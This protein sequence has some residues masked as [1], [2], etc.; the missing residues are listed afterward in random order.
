MT[1]PLGMYPIFKAKRRFFWAQNWSIEKCVSF[2]RDFHQPCSFSQDKAMFKISYVYIYI[3]IHVYIYICIYI[4]M[5]IYTQYILIWGQ[6][7]FMMNWTTKATILMISPMY[8]NPIMCGQLLTC[9]PMDCHSTVIVRLNVCRPKTD[10]VPS[11]S[12]RFMQKCKFY[13]Q[14]EWQTL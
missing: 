2:T 13:G 6:L 9:E 5:Y 14:F 1:K 7:L 4:Y 11:I 8:I 12:T 3:Y 10:T